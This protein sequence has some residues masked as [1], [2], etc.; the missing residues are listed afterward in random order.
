M[1]FVPL[2]QNLS[3]VNQVTLLMGIEMLVICISN[4]FHALLGLIQMWR[5]QLVKHV[6]KDTFVYT[7][8]VKS[9]QPQRSFTEESFVHKATFAQQVA[10]SLS[11]AL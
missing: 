11:L 5:I 1:L 7:E 3:I 6:K 4:A 9:I 2:S 10:K 8:Q